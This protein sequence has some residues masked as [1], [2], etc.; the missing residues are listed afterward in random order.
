M[1]FV[2][3][4]RLVDFLVALSLF[5]LIAALVYNN[6][7]QQ[8]ICSFTF[9]PVFIALIFIALAFGFLVVLK[10]KPFKL[11]REGLK[12]KIS[13]LFFYMLFLP[14]VITPIFR[15][16]FKVPYLFC[17][18]CPTKCIF[19][20][21]RPYVFPAF[22]A[23]NLDNRF[24]CFNWCPLGKVQDL[25]AKVVKKQVVLPRFLSVLRYIVLAFIIFTY[26]QILH[27]RRNPAFAGTD[28]FLFMF[29]NAFI[30]STA[31]FVVFLIFFG[32]SFFVQ[33]FFCNYFCPIGAV[34]DT[35]LFVQRKLKL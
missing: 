34:S 7:T 15:C 21:V 33:R 27:A 8:Y 29:K 23:V 14:M 20:H 1:Q 11:P 19:G 9:H 24:W 10:I 28:M 22:L 5:V 32:I 12:Q 3:K 35:L 6:T 13:N 18:V 25:Q 16:Y 31:V 26:F 2:T 30:F 4:N 17:H